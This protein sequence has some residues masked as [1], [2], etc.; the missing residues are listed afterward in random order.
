MF[1]PRTSRKKLE[2][3]I[4]TLDALSHLTETTDAQGFR[5]TGIDLAGANSASSPGRY[6]AITA[7]LRDGLTTKKFALSKDQSRALVAALDLYNL[8]RTDNVGA[9]WDDEVEQLFQ[10]LQSL[11]AK[12]YGEP[13]Y[14]R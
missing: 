4:A 14:P 12:T 6:D 8:R 3:V 13:V 1:H 5:I 11:F 2:K 7:T 9:H 10:E